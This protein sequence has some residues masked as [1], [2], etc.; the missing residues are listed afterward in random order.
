MA[1]NL[2]KPLK[3]ILTVNPVEH[4][5]LSPNEEELIVV[6]SDYVIHYHLTDVLN[7]KDVWHFF[8]VSLYVN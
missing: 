2:E 6:V 4:L 7:A 1:N 8:V 5:A 3:N